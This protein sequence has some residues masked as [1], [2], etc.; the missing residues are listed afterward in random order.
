MQTP[1]KVVCIY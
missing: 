1:Y